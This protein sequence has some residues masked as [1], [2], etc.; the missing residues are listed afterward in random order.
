MIHDKLKIEILIQLFFFSNFAQKILPGLYIG[1]LKDSQDKAQ[2]KAHH[3]THIVS[4]FEEAKENPHF[5]VYT[6]RLF[7]L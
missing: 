3:I 7:L 2:L 4:V 5:K 1:T 6:N